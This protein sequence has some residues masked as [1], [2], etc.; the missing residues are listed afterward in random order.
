[1]V[2]N[3]NFDKE[4]KK[5]EQTLLHLRKFRLLI[6]EN[7]YVEKLYQSHLIKAKPQDFGKLLLQSY[8]YQGFLEKMLVDV[9]DDIT[10]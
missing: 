7:I 2:Y 3:T 1:M 6:E 10:L 4:M 5:D 8:D 9:F